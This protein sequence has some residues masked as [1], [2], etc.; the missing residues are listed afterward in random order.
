MENNE[1]SRLRE[2]RNTLNRT[3]GEMADVFGIRTQSYGSY[4]RGVNSMRYETLKILVEHFKVNAN[5]FITGEGNMFLTDTQINSEDYISIHEFDEKMRTM[6]N[7]LLISR[8]YMSELESHNES[9]KKYVA[10][11]EVKKS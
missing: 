7:E 8:K 4:E 11:L 6:E 5:W 2:L 10:L 9:L 1:A 3:Q